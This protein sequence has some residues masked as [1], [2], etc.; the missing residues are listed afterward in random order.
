MLDQQLKQYAT[1]RQWDIL[2]AID[3][4]GNSLTKAATALGINVSNVSRSKTAVLHKAA[5]QGYAPNAQ[6]HNPTAPGFS[7]IKTSTMRGPDDEVK[8]RWTQECPDKQQQEAMYRAAVEA[9][10]D[11]IPQ[12]L[13]VPVPQPTNSDLLVAYPVG[14]HHFGMQAWAEETLGEDY[15][16][17]RAEELL[18]KAMDHLVQVS[19]DSDEAA[20][21]VLGDFLHFDGMEAVTPGHGHN[22][23]A[24]ARFQLIVRVALKSIRYLVQKALT[25]H[26]HV[27]LILESGNH[28]MS[29]MPAFTE[30]FYMHYEN[31]PR[32]TVDRS[33]H[34][35]HAFQFGK[36]LIATHHGDKIKPAALL[37][38]VV[39]DFAEIW[40]L[41]EHRYI[42]TGHVHHDNQKELAGLMTESHGILAPKD[43]YAAKGGWRSR[44]SMKSITYHREFGEVGRQ[45]FTPQMM[46]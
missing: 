29:S 4:A 8:I 2:V 22:L 13:A 5:K 43:A 10:C 45:M 15:D 30:M 23:D 37:G 26:Q 36:N 17:G 44:Q 25:K 6:L 24:A 7:I 12:S 42:H 33:P 38:A 3:A 19:D 41:T 9:M 40:G 20:I 34:N 21:L 46:K 14:D 16:L 35:C 31:D 1:D 18:I 11:S 27:R 28:D 32:I 39:T